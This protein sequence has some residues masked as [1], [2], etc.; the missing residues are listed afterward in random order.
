QERPCRF[1][2]VMLGHF[3]G[4][5]FRGVRLD[6]NRIGEVVPMLA[7]P[8]TRVL[9]DRNPLLMRCLREQGQT[10]V[11][12]AGSTW[13]KTLIENLSDEPE[14]LWQDL[15]LWALLSRYPEKLLEY[16]VPLQR[17]K[18]LRAIPGEAVKTLPLERKAIEE[19]VAQIEMFYRDV[20]EEIDSSDAFR[21][22]VH[23]AS[24]RLFKEFKLLRDLL[25]AARFAPSAEDIQAV[26]ERFRDCPGLNATEIVALDDLVPPPRLHPPDGYA[27]DNPSAWIAWTEKDYI[28]YRHWQTKSGHD[29]AEL[30]KVVQS[31]SDWYI[32][33]YATLHQST[34]FSLVH[35]LGAFG[36]SIRNDTLSL[37]ILVD[38]LPLTFWP[39]FQ[40]AMQRA[41]FH[42]YALEFR[43]SPLPT[44][45]EFVK[46]TL[47]SG[48][49]NCPPGTN[50]ESLL[51]NRAGSDWN[52]RQAVYLSNLKM[53]SDF[54]APE[55]PT[56]VLLNLLTADEILHD[57][58]A[59]KGTTHEEELHRLFMRVAGATASLL[60]RWPGARDAFGLYVLTDH[61]ACRVLDQER[62][63]FESRIAGKLFADERKRFAVV[64]KG[65]ADTVPENLWSLGYRFVPPFVKGENVFFIPRGHSTVSSGAGK[66]YAHGGATPEEVIV[67]VAVFKATK[68][69]RKAPKARFVGLQIDPATGHA[70]F[71]I[72]RLTRLSIDIL[73]PNS[74]DLR[75]VRVTIL[76]PEAQLKG[77]EL[78]LVAKGETATVSL[79]C[80]FNRSALGRGELSIQLVYEIAGEE[81]AMELKAAGVF[82]SA[83]TGGFSLK[84]LK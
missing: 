81:R 52:G 55:T 66:G 79:E 13:E 23:G 30:E 77:Q 39:I 24:G 74:E 84:D 14:Q 70:L 33:D 2:E 32:R 25:S 1:E 78:P 38:G 67:P 59:A 72:L 51:R 61:G 48:D 69:D 17:V 6:R 60:E 71:H 37:I 63:S 21:R 57:D 56:V 49:W 22:V 8:E 10:W 53:L 31:F 46:P 50:Y 35:A 75:V 47:I 76:S 82:K 12:H 34:A 62:H 11:N 18:F 64:E 26:K 3:L 20:G 9:L 68:A 83:V 36:D 42:R 16:V 40:E 7:R 19:A 54:T 27:F 4:E 44:D 58:M 65:V 15:S 43:F 80:N 45:T 29:D 5:A 41:G 73:N 28:P